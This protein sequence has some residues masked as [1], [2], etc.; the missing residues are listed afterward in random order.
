MGFLNLFSK[1]KYSRLVHLPSGSFTLDRNG[2]VI[3]STLPTFFPTGHINQI[4]QQVLA[5]FN[6]AQNAQMP[7][8]EI[9]VSYAALRIL[10][11]ELRGGA[12]VYLMPQAL[13]QPLRPAL[14]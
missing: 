12:I 9:I 7:L 8:S 5:T 10:A 2:R 14:N 11:R 13:N 4:A 1:T 6:A 3:S